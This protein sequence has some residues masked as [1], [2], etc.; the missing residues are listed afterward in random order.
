MTQ[1]SQDGSLFDRFADGEAGPEEVARINDLLEHDDLR[2]R[3]MSLWNANNTFSFDRVDWPRLGNAATITT[4]SRYMKHIMWNMGLNP[5][6]ISN[7][8]PKRLLKKVSE[9]KA[10]RVRKALNDC[11]ILTKIARWDPD[12]RWNMAVEAV[13]R[14][15]SKGHRVSLVA[16][17]G[18]ESHGAEVL[19][20][21]RTVGLQVKEVE[22]SG[23]G[24]DDRLRAIE[25]AG[26]A[27]ILNLKFFMPE[28]LSRLIYYASDGVLANSGHEPFGLVGLETMAAGGVAFTG[29]T[30]E[31]YAVP[32][33]NAIVLE[34]DDPEEIV[35]YVTYL[36][37]HADEKDRIRKAA[38]RTARQYTWEQVVTNLVS[39]LDYLVRHKGIQL[40]VAPS[41]GNGN[42]SLPQAHKADWSTAF[43][44]PT[45]A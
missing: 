19:D 9:E 13:A 16:R 38:R 42:G 28:D 4:V 36:E 37:E 25:A 22:C 18:M 2:N 23:D 45:P 21:A 10:E 1:P 27:D 11:L 32:L 7:G 41:N 31:D 5:L 35:E 17:G 34:T 33:E 44:Y 43:Q 8:I 15:K 39:K 26:P 6:V 20:N 24:L 29:C 14:L 3:V 30:G 40:G 12:K